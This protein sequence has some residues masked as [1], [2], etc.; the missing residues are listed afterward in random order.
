MSTERP[1]ETAL[2]VWE[3]WY[4]KAVRFEAA[5]R[6]LTLAVDFRAGSRLGVAGVEGQRPVHD[7]VSKRYR[8]LDFFQHECHQQ[9]C[10][11]VLRSKV[12]PMK[13]VARL[14]RNHI[15]GIVAWTRSRHTNGFLE[16]LKGLFQ[17]ARRK[18]R[19]HRSLATMRPVIFLLAGMLDFTRVNP[20][21]PAALPR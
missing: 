13:A 1:V 21:I 5:D 7:T 9:W 8:H 16:A 14:V 11:N 20:Y 2:G 6:T 19:G 18:A 10:T 17:A 4:V 15:E 12:E 3:P